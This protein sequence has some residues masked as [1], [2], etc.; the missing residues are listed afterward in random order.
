MSVR[1]EPQGSFTQGWAGE[2]PSPVAMPAIYQQYCKR[3]FDI[4]L[5]MTLLVPLL[6]LCAVIWLLIRVN[7]G[8]PVLFRQVRVGR[9]GQ[10]FHILKFRTMFLGSDLVSS[11]VVL[12]RRDSRATALGGSEEW[13]VDE[14]PQLLNVL[15]GE[16]RRWA[17]RPDVPGFADRLSGAEKALLELRPGVTGPASLKYRNEDEILAAQADP[18]TYNRE[19]VFRDKVRLN[20]EYARNVAFLR[21]LY[22]LVQTVFPTSAVN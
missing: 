18:E 13:K 10:P 6:P 20:L 21:D 1:E 14:L 9:F 7:D 19:I 12:W 16:M 3:A 17:H 2:A 4:A 11:M 5:S 22:Y 8:R 15:R